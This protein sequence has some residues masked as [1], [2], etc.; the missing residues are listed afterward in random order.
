M[1]L[2]VVEY[3]ILKNQLVMLN[4][5]VEALLKGRGIDNATKFLVAKGMTYQKAN[6]L[7]KKKVDRI[8]YA[9]M[10]QLCLDCNCTPDDLFVWVKDAAVSV[11][12]DHALYKLKPK[13]AVVNPVERMK[14][15]SVAKL[16]KL[17][18]FMDG[19]EREV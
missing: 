15:L 19:L 9:T 8:D 12:D 13:A 14:S 7:L 17:K 18:E 16:E 1:N 6:R 10:E 5:N 3:F 4:L 2:G 11:P